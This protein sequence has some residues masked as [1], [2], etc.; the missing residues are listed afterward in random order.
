MLVMDEADRRRGTGRAAPSASGTACAGANSPSAAR[1]LIACAIRHVASRL[2][3]ASGLPQIAI[4][5]HVAVRRTV[6]RSCGRSAPRSVAIGAQFEPRLARTEDH[7]RHEHMQ[8]VDAAS[9]D[10]ARD[11]A[12]AAFDQDARSCRAATSAATMARGAMRPSRR[13]RTRISS[14]P[15]AR[16]RAPRRRGARPSSASHA[17]DAG[18][19]AAG[20]VDDDTGGVAARHAPHVELGSSAST[21]P[22]PTTTAS[23]SARSRCRWSSARPPLISAGLPARRRDTP[24]ERLAELGDHEGASRMARHGAIR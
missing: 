10:E 9:L 12:R 21:V 11:G 7:G 15:P 22:T 24:V 16:A 14:T 3:N 18:R 5:Q 6:D 20:R 8:P 19:H 17:A 4:E 13:G 1:P 2:V 23:T